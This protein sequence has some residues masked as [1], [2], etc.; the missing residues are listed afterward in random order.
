MPS[1]S[2][3]PGGR[4][5]FKLDRNGVRVVLTV[6]ADTDV[7]VVFIDWTL[8]LTVPLLPVY[9]RPDESVTEIPVDRK[10]ILEF[11]SNRCTSHFE[12]TDSTAS[13]PWRV[14]VARIDHGRRGG[15]STVTGSGR[16]HRWI[17]ARF[18]RQYQI[19]DGQHGKTNGKYDHRQLDVERGPSGH[20]ELTPVVVRRHSEY[21]DRYQGQNC[22]HHR[23]QQL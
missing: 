5:F 9:G 7:T 1:A 14:P 11:I 20:P 2:A 10:S 6:E 3:L 22:S 4:G 13:P 23:Q 15:P 8:P 18:T 21:D 17:T 12:L 19:V 16:Q